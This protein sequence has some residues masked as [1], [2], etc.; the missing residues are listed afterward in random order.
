[1]KDKYKDYLAVGIVGVIAFYAGVV[2]VIA[3]TVIQ[4]I[5]AGSW[6]ALKM[7][8][9]TSGR[10]LNLKATK[11]KVREIEGSQGEGVNHV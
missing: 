4:T 7:A 6:G 5:V 2:F 3:P 11:F 8:N 1:M 9:F 10:I